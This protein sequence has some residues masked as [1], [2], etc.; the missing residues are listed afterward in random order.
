MPRVHQLSQS[1]H[2]FRT[3]V[4]CIR[5]HITQASAVCCYICQPDQTLGEISYTPK[6]QTPDP[7]SGS[8]CHVQ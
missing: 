7:C 1:E 6:L 3:N 8:P 5:Q 4:K 2:L